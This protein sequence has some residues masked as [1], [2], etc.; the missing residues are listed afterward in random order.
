MSFDAFSSVSAGSSNSSSSEAIAPSSAPSSAPETASQSSAPQTTHSTPPEA[1]TSIREKVQQAQ[2]QL[3]QAPG[4]QP[5]PQAQVYTPNFKF[6]VMDKEHE[7]SEMFRP[8]IKDPETEK[9][10]KE[11]HEKAYGLDT[12][13][14]RFNE[15]REQFKAVKQKA[16]QYDSQLNELR[17]T[18]KRGDLESWF[19][20]MGVP[21]E[22]ILQYV[23]NKAQ[24]Q[25]LPPEQRKVLD[26]KRAAEQKAFA[27]EKERAQYQ[28]Q[29]QEQGRQAK[30]FA[31]QVEL[32][33]PDVKAF[34]D[35][36]NARA[37]TPEAFFEEVRRTGEYAWFQSNGQV[38]LTPEQAIQQVMA[39]WGALAKPAEAPII[40]PQGMSQQPMAAPQAQAPVKRE[41]P[42][43]PNVAGRQSNSVAKSKPRSIADLKK[44]A[45][46]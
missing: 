20:M 15:T 9:Q 23:I 38:D 45:A 22:K 35:Q 40:P 1:A 32:A 4:Q 2:A 41:A 3:N 8:L 43:I 21:E 39:R 18:F 11:L 17:E 27:L 24:Y 14:N 44:L 16:D 19:K 37:G 10:I 28:Q 29:I 42:A 36:F 26:E 5:N 7:I 25:Q 46:Q 6:K 31:L 34:S 12:V 30:Q 33:K 13:K